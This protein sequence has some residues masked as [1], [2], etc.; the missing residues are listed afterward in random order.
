MHVEVSRY[1]GEL[2][3]LFEYHGFLGPHV[4]NAKAENEQKKQVK[5]GE[6]I[7]SGNW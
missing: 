2:S 3:E 5:S 1:S 4:R 6:L 7:S